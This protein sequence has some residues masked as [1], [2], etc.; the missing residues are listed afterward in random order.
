MAPTLPQLCDV[1]IAPP[2]DAPP[3]GSLLVFLTD[4]T[5]IAHRLVRRRAT[6]WI[7]Q[8]DGRRGPDRPVA[9]DHVIGVVVAAFDDTGRCWPGR[10]HRLAAV[11]WIARY[12]ALRP[13]RW[14]WHTL[15]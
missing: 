6:D 11:F 4:D 12:H 1:E 10:L 14:L 9:P 2:P 8:G 3:L 5:L 15:P 13:I 7:T